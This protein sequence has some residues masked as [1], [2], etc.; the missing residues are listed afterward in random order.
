MKCI[1]NA[2]SGQTVRLESSCKQSHSRSLQGVRQSF[3]TL[4]EKK[5]GDRKAGHMCSDI[6]RLC[7]QFNASAGFSFKD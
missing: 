5:Q 6:N 4:G 3:L 7:I 1:R 2:L